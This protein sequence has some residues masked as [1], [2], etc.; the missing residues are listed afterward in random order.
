MNYLDTS[1]VILLLDS[2][3]Y[4]FNEVN[5]IINNENPIISDLG[6]LEL[7]SFLSRNNIENPLS[8]AIHTIKKYKINLLSKIGT[9]FIPG[10]GNIN[11]LFYNSLNLSEKLKL[12]T[13]DLMHTSYCIELKNNDY[14]IKNLFT[15]DKE[16]IKSK[17]ILNKYKIELKIV[18]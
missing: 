7:T 3:D 8:Y 16:F 10:F 5:N 15:A 9:S 14:D 1:V 18:N 17:K 6:F 2:K 13:L 11:T 4:R 12:R